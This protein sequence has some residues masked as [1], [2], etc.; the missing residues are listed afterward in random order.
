MKIL[1]LLLWRKKKSIS[2]QIQKV[3]H[4]VYKHPH[5]NSSNWEQGFSLSAGPQEWEGRKTVTLSVECHELS[6][7]D[8]HKSLEK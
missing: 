3:I 6:H 5:R 2:A 1:F 4:N 8:L 7:T